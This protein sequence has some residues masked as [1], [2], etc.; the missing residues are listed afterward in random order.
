MVQIGEKHNYNI[1]LTNITDDEV[2]NNLNKNSCLKK[3]VMI[4]AEV[5]EKLEVE[6][7]TDDVLS[8]KVKEKTI[9][10]YCFCN[11]KDLC[12][13]HSGSGSSLIGSTTTMAMLLGLLNMFKEL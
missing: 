7:V 6:G 8:V 5:D 9:V 10:T 13:K 4:G 2:K 11:D 12:N 1:M 3:E